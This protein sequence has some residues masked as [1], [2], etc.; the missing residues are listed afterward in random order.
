MTSSQ[1]D[2]HGVRRGVGNNEREVCIDNRGV[3]ATGSSGLERPPGSLLQTFHHAL[4]RVLC[5]EVRCMLLR[6]DGC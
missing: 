3:G 1:V 6:A 2:M 5:G 4:R